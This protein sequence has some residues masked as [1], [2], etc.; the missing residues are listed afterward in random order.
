MADALD[1]LT[2][3]LAAKQ[4]G[5]ITREQLLRLGLGR[6]AIQYRI[7][8]RRLIPVYR[9]VYAV[10]HLPMT[11]LPR[12]FAAVLACGEGA[13]LSH[14]SAATL[15]GFSKHWEMPLEV[16]VATSHRQRGGINLHRSRTLTRRDVTWQLGIRVTSPARTVL[17]YAPRLTGKALSRFVYDALRSPYLYRPALADVL[18][19]NPTHPGAKRRAALRAGSARA[20]EFA[21]RGRLLGLRRALRLAHADHQHLPVRL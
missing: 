15:W 4:F 9:G 13:A 11:P 17:D 10:G 8:A 5:Y 6:R 19:R 18:N 16:T 14:G 1:R 21:A 3:V 20:G 7:A 12:A 2:G